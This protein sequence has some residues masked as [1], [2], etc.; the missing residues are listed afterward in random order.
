METEA[1]GRESEPPVTVEDVV[2]GCG[3]KNGLHRAR[4]EP[5]DA[6][7]DAAERP[8]AL[9]LAC[10]ADDRAGEPDIGLDHGR[11]LVGGR[12]ARYVLE[13]LVA[14]LLEGGLALGLVEGGSEHAP[15]TLPP[16][17]VRGAAFGR[18][19]RS[20]GVLIGTGLLIV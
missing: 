10:R 19:R 14:A 16:S 6:V 9:D 4:A 7:A 1:V 17:G 15:A 2:R 5:L 12:A 20:H 3:P 18:G 11:H 8:A 13:G